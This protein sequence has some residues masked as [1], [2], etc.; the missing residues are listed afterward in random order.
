[1]PSWNTL[2]VGP[3]LRRLIAERLG[4][5]MR[6]VWV[7][8]GG[9]EY[10]YLV[11]NNDDHLIYQREITADDL[12]DEQTAEDQTWLEAMQHEDCP[13]WD[14]DLDEALDLVYGLEYRIDESNGVFRAWVE[15]PQYPGEAEAKPLA[16]VRAWLTA[17]E[18]EARAK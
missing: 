17:T 18:D 6:K 8:S 11:Y 12:A 9:I 2:P 7:G 4:W 13:L 10:D 14:Q 1:M 3:Q 5:H 16:L 15:S